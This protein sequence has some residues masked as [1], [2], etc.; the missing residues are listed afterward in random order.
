MP[1]L[2]QTFVHE[3]DLQ[4]IPFNFQVLITIF[5]YEYRGKSNKMFRIANANQR[6]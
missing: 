1:I 2:I 5:V 4:Y 3:T 6:S